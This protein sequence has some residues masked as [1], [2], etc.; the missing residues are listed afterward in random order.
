[1]DKKV[2]HMYKARM[3]PIAN[4]SVASVSVLLIAMLFLDALWLTLM[5]SHYA[6]SVYR[7]QKSELKVRWLGAIVAYAIMFASVIYIAM[8]NVMDEV[9]KGRGLLS[10]SIRHAALLGFVTYGV[11]NATSYAIYSDYSIVTCII[12]TI[13]GATLYTILAFVTASVQVR[14]A[15]A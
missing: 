7:V 10:A 14:Y 3:A 11:Y 8:P 15:N 12:D 2:R 5:K 1:M 9:N 6:T 13:W 4:L